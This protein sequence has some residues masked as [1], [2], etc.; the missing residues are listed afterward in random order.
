MNQPDD[1]HLHKDVRPL[2]DQSDSA[3]TAF[4]E[5]EMA[6]IPY[7]LADA[8]LERL[9]RISL[10]PRCER[11]PCALI[12]GPSNNGKTALISQFARE[13]L[14]RNS[15]AEDQGAK[16]FARIVAPALADEGRLYLEILKTFSA[17]IGRLGSSKELLKAAEFHLSGS[18]IQLLFIDEFQHL[19]AGSTQQHRACM[20]GLKNLST[21]LRISIIGCGTEAAYN[22]IQSDPQ[23]ENR[24]FPMELPA[25]KFG[26]DF[27]ILVTR[28]ES[29]LPLRKPSM[30]ASGAI[31]KLIFQRSNGLLGEIIAL[32]KSAARHAILTSKSECIRTE[33]INSCGYLGP[34][35][36][37]NRFL[38][39]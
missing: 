7:P 26:E 30:L 37:R 8:H 24:F 2:L 25:W 22:A 3:R 29:R 33:E 19:I 39:K 15:D 21:K 13:S 11:M 5:K 4:L 28:I 17:S 35:Q 38:G 32:C 34:E 12:Y 20:N 16:T 27:K 10:M 23:L 1:S 9:H 14:G 31:A 36:R 6:W 18:G